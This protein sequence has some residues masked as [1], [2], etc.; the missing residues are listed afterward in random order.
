METGYM[1]IGRTLSMRCD[2]SEL[3]FK[4]QIDL[5]RDLMQLTG[6]SH[7]LFNG[8]GPTAAAVTGAWERMVEKGMKK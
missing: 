2:L 3:N 7:E 5:L 4:T 6:F 8:D 1:S